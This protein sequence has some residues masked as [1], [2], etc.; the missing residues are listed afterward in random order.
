MAFFSRGKCNKFLQ[1]DL[2]NEVF[3]SSNTTLS[4]SKTTTEDTFRG[5]RKTEWG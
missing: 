4:D 1:V 5:S 3:Q 2:S